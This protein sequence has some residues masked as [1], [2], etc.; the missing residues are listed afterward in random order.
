MT[1][2]TFLSPALTTDPTNVGMSTT[3]L[4]MLY[5]V[6]NWVG[7]GF[8]PVLGHFIDRAGARRCLVAALVALAA[9]M[10]GLSACHTWP[11]FLA[12]FLGI[13][14]VFRAALEVWCIVPINLWFDQRR[15]RAMA[16]FSIGETR[17][18]RRCITPHPKFC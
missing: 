3:R 16:V 6:A 14:I 10:L 17:G 4:S 1:P 7:A 18:G 13:R 9:C 15:G 11:A 12:A 5:A 2:M 8:S